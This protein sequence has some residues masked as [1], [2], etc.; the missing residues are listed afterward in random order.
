MIYN[1]DLL[2]FSVGYYVSLYIFVSLLFIKNVEILIIQIIIWV[3][4]TQRTNSKS[5]RK[6]FLNLYSFIT[7]FYIS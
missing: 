1:F 7:C 3:Y 6:L 4:F 2:L 5:G